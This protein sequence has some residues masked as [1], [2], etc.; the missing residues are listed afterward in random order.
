VT[1]ACSILQLTKGHKAVFASSV[2]LG[3]VFGRVFTS[4]FDIKF[5]LYG[6]RMREKLVLKCKHLGIVFLLF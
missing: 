2:V 5:V 4:L 3:S 1:K 6:R